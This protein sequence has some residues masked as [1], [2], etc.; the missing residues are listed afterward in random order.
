M[1]TNNP[2]A[3]TRTGSGEYVK[4]TGLENFKFLGVNPNKQ[5]LEAW[6]GREI[7]FDPTYDL[8]SD[9]TGNNQRPLHLWFKGDTVGVQ[10]FILNIGN[11]PAIS[12]SGNY[13]IITSTGNITWAKAS[14][15]T[16]VKPQFVDHK[17]LTQGE[18][19]LITFVQRLVSFDRN[20]NEDFY[21]QM[22][23]LKQDAA[24][25][26]NGNYDGLNQ[27]A[28]DMADTYVVLPMVVKDKDEAGLD[29]NIVTKSRMSI[30][31]TQYNLDK[32]MFSGKVSDWA[33]SRFMENVTTDP[34]L[35]KGMYSVDL[36]PFNRDTVMNNVPSNPST[37]GDWNS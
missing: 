21:T 7:T 14:G 17:P 13:Q 15:S 19:A 2:Y 26:Y 9:P 37:A 6:Q 28:K 23:E 35:L 11:T 4:Y 12:K 22:Q 32:V 33:K 34:N 5:Q 18:A 20:S 36:V 29:G 24:S 3:G 31:A 10:R 8:V 30:G 27:L 25:V 16:E 1:S